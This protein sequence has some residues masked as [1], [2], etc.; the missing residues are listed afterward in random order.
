MSICA[1]VCSL[2]S[3]GKEVL[4][5]QPE[6]FNTDEILRDVANDKGMERIKRRTARCEKGG[7]WCID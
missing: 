3:C 4:A 2:W 1:G 5:V 6:T 7:S